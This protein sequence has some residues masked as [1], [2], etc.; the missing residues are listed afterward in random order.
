MKRT[1]LPRLLAALLVS[2]TFSAC[3][4]G[5]KA[6]DTN[7]ETGDYKT[8]DPDPGQS[9]LS[10]SATAGLQRDTANRPTGRQVYEKAADAKDRNNDGIAD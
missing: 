4:T 8:K 5:T 10:D 9:T 7:V 2:A 6:G 3:D 1:L